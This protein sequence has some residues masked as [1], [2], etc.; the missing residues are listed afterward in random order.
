MQGFASKETEQLQRK[1]L[2]I[3]VHKDPEMFSLNSLLNHPMVKTASQQAPP[4]Y[5]KLKF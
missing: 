4:T 3:L 2:Q 5:T 1:D